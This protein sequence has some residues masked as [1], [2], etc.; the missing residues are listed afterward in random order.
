MQ[1]LTLSHL[2]TTMMSGMITDMTNLLGAISRTSQP[3]LL[4]VVDVS[5]AAGRHTEPKQAIDFLKRNGIRVTAPWPC[6]YIK[7]NNSHFL[8]PI[9]H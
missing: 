1:H 5:P 7:L 6:Y 2:Q 4:T 8:I 3:V 9:S